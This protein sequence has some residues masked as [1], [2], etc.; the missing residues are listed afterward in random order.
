MTDLNEVQI[1]V[2]VS[3][4]QSFTLASKRLGMP[5][6]NVS[7]AI[8]NLENRLGVRLLE[9]TT[10]SM[11]LTDAGEMYF[12][13]CKRVLEDAEQADLMIGALQ[14]KP[15]GRLR[16][17]APV[18]FAR[19]ILAP[20]LG[21][22]L[23]LYPELRLQLQLLQGSTS[24]LDKGLDVV[25]R[26]GPLE[27]SGLL[28]KPIMKIRLGIY[29][30]P[31][32]LQKSNALTAPTDLREHRCI[33]TNCGSHG[34]PADSAVWRLS[35]GADQQEVRVES[36][37]AVPD[38]T[39]NHQLAVAG[40]GIALIPQ[41]V[42]RADVE[43]GCLTHVLNEWEPDPVRLHAVYPSRL[44][45]SPNVRVFLQFLRKRSEASLKT[46]AMTL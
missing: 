41:S 24:T 7:R 39:I 42:A 18:A 32:Y 34:E 1:F 4:S 40:A 45:T 13:R 29:A 12:E 23:A 5:K 30:S 9:R 16:V 10:R 21:E 36:C 14:S 33:T 6:S 28:V 19:F 37:V 35:R 38:P 20:V 31:A 2:Q 11:A 8:Q 44:A 26:P 25:I 22:F 15:R 43:R 3:Q 17:G 46:M 27:H